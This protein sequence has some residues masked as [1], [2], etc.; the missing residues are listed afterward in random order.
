[1]NEN[2]ALL[3]GG[4]ILFLFAVSQLSGHLRILFGEQAR[5]IISRFTSNLFKAL[6]VGM[7]TTILLSS[8]SA[9]IILVIVF[10][11]AKALK[12]KNAMGLIMG[13]NIGTTFSSQLFALDITQYAF[14]PLL[15][16]L[17]F[18]FMAKDEKRR[19]QALALLFFGLLF[20]ALFL[21]EQ[22]VKPL[23]GEPDFMAFIAQIENNTLQ[24]IITG[25]ALTVVIQSSSAVV[26]MAIALAKENIINL[27]G[28]LA[29]MLGAELGTCSN[30]LL[31]T[32][33]GS[34]QAIKAG[35]FHLWFNLVTILLGFIL[36]EPFASLVI[37]LTAGADIY[38]QVARGHMLF[39]LG[40]VILYLPF[41]GVTLRA[42]N[43]LLPDKGPDENR[44]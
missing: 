9:V 10:I 21:I 26:G 25:G 37:E 4:L 29:I 42:L 3:I 7:V 33:K 27:T 28:G 14:I 20:F 41:V 24:G 1:M 13:A 31:A 39:N 35:V 43:Y 32:V 15:A 22:S 2:L 16:G 8:S 38:T 5:N 6:L 12:F 40:G 30:T 23:R 36:F 19:I 44:I 34:R 17:I 11:N 18:W